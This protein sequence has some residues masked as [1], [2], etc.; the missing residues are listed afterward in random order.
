[1]AKVFLAILALTFALPASGDVL[2]VAGQVPVTNGDAAVMSRLQSLGH[3]VTVVDDAASTAASANGKELVVISESVASGSVGNKFNQ[4]AVPLIVFEPWVYDNLGLTGTVASTDY[5]FTASQ[6]QL[7]MTGTHPLTA[8]LTGDVTV[9]SAASS[10][11][12]GIPAPAAVVAATLRNDAS[13]PTIFAY[14]AGVQLANGLAAP[15][16]RVALHP[17]AGATIAWNATGQSLFDA[18][19]QWAVN[20][21]PPPAI[22]RIL[23]LGDSI[24]R[25]T[26]GHWSYRRNLEAALVDGDCSFDLVGTEFGPASGPGAALA[27]RDH[28]GH[29]GFRTDQIRAGLPGWLPGNEPDWVLLHIGTNDVLQGTSISA[30][31]TQIGLIIDIL[32]DANANVGILLA[33][34]IPNRPANEASVVALN[35]G[36]A[37]LAAQKHQPGTSPVI[38]VDHYSGYST[39]TH[40]YDEVHPN[41]AGEAIMAQR[42]AQALLPMIAGY[43][44]P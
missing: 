19:V 24:T 44:A 18:A 9:G 23:P 31:I 16:R 4:V 22:V 15:A 37:T 7:R 30:A 13:R 6:T 12:W 25:G 11:S 14:E 5:G 39:F 28:E 8:G 38:V 34:V 26:T 29:G 40:N 21:P 10:F 41:D 42:W 17:N 43:C 3:A 33:Q 20:G 36:I 1:M 32:R 27:D 2:L 35:D